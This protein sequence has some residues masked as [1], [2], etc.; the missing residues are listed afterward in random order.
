MLV[1]R[2]YLSGLIQAEIDNGI[3]AE[4]IVLGGFSQ[5]GAM[6]L[7]TGLTTK[8]KLAGIV[9]MS[10]YLPLDTKLPE[11]LRE[12]NVNQKTPIL[13]C[14]GTVDIVVPTQVG[15]GSYELLKKEGF[16]VTWKEYEG[17]GH[18]ASLEELDEV[19]A[20]IAGCLSARGEDKKSEL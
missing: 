2:A 14:H 6:S 11:F 13:M 16:D 5:G 10:S 18:A 12:S 9:G 7:F 1:S 17:M 3:P 19:E 15:K 8:F 20:F 4:R